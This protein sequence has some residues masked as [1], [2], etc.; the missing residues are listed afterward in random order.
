MLHVQ[1][2]FI[3]VSSLLDLRWVCGRSQD[4]RLREFPSWNSTAASR[5]T[6][7]C[8]FE[9]HMFGGKVSRS[10]Q[11]EWTHFSS[12]LSPPSYT[13][14][15]GHNRTFSYL[16]HHGRG[17]RHSSLDHFLDKPLPTIRKG[18]HPWILSAEQML[19]PKMPAPQALTP[20]TPTKWDHPPN[21]F[22]RTQVTTLT[23][24]LLSNNYWAGK[25]A[26]SNI[27]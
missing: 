17:G 23:T 6:L 21:F 13:I 15:W 12:F 11:A 25:N 22:C 24:F 9:Y 1:E 14:S 7:L 18:H 26:T 27:W 16:S 3:H 20:R 5:S 19:Q 10:V 2:H 8:L 4:H